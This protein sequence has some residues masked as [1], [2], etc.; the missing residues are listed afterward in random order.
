MHGLVGVGA[1]KVKHQELHDTI[2]T[3]GIVHGC[4]FGVE[5]IHLP[6]SYDEMGKVVEKYK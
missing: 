6:Y 5:T 1:L 2:C 4:I 3:F